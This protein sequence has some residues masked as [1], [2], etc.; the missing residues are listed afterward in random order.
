MTAQA[1]HESGAWLLRTWEQAADLAPLERAL[2]LAGDPGLPSC[3]LG[4]T[5]ERLL[6]LRQQMFGP[7][8]EVTTTCTQCRAVVEF[9]LSTRELTDV[10]PSEPF[11]RLVHG[12]Y[13][14]QW[15]SPTPEDLLAVASSSDPGDS[16]R[17]RCLR[18]SH[19]DGEP[20][21]HRELPAEA[22]VAVDEMLAEADPLAEIRVTVTCPECGSDFL[23]RLD[24]EAFVW[25]E[26]D[27]RARR[28]LAEVDTLARA[29]GWTEPE[30][31]ALS[32]ARRSAYL[33]LVL[34]GAV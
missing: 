9:E 1:P 3:P 29:Y 17:D 12:E 25:A 15:C 22:W 24:P 11:A 26:I 21:S 27:A 2:L 30:V 23:S 6:L 18:V 20:R 19:V 13:V 28:V 4:K 34:D 32:E 8:L 33:R 31:L 7:I 16:L 14:V 10:K 5:N